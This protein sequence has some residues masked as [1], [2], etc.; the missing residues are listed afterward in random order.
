[1]NVPQGPQFSQMNYSNQHDQLMAMLADALATGKTVSPD[2]LE[3]V[4]AHA[5]A[6]I[7][8][9][10]SLISAFGLPQPSK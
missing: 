6:S 3:L 8:Y 7:A 9:H 2:K 1:M 5:L 10:L 4:K